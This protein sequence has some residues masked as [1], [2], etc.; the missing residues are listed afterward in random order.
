M[1]QRAAQVLAAGLTPLKIDNSIDYE[2]FAAHVRWLL[3][4]GCDGVVIF[5]TTGEGNSFSVAERQSALDALLQAD[6]APQQLI[7]ATGCCALPDTVSLTTHALASGVQR[8]LVLPPFYYKTVDENDVFNS[9]CE[10][11]EQID[12]PALRIY[13]YHFPKMAIVGFS[14]P[15][16][17][18]LHE[19]FPQQIAGVKDSSGDREHTE[20]LN[21]C[22][23]SL[24]IY[25]GSEKF[26]L[27]YLRDG[28]I[29]CISATTNL[30]S[31]LAA[32]VRDHRDDP[33]ADAYQAQL[34]R[35]RTLLE[36][37]PMTGGL[38]GLLALHTGMPEWR[39]IRVPLSCLA[40]E[41][42]V[43]MRD[44]LLQLSFPI[45]YG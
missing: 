32:K 43:E 2:Q 45:Q 42:V 18:R 5:G 41:R 22:F 26:L 15:L 33:E 37:Y 30:T 28:G 23:P 6:I 7:V 8:V 35:V 4:N 12:D 34:S 21:R 44:R 39:N 20:M 40:E 38:K 16:I 24:K 17:E 13:L 11:I 3:A 14:Q 27:N 1:T 29:G 19:Q 9:F 25:A 31:L 10:L 36:G